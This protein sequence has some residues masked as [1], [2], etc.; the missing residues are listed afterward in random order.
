MLPRHL[1]PG[2]SADREA[3]RERRNAHNFKLWCAV[4]TATAQKEG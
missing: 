4:V 2:T 3:A 1:V